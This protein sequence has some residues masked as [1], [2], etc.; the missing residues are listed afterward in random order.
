MT[1]SVGL[2]TL[3]LTTGMMLA[4]MVAMATPINSTSNPEEIAQASPICRRILPT[5]QLIQT[6]GVLL[7]S[8]P[9]RKSKLAGVGYAPRE[10]FET[11][12][13]TVKAEGLIWLEVTG[14][15]AG[16]IWAG[17]GNTITNIGVCLK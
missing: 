15:R 11:T 17:N 6:N 10:T 4:G 2:G 14:S 9:S 7:R 3:G 12:V 16:W 13:N 8:E 1:G 5:P